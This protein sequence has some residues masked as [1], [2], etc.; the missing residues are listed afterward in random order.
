MEELL[1]DQ[2]CPRSANQK[3]R[4]PPQR[5]RQYPPDRKEKIFSDWLSTSEAS[6]A[7]TARLSKVAINVDVDLPHSLHATIRA[8]QQL[9]C[10]KAPESDAIPTEVYKHGGP[11]LMDHPTALFLEMWPH[12]EVPQD[13]KDASIHLEQGLL[14]ESQFGLRSHH[15]TKGVIFAAREIQEKFQQMRTHLHYIFVDLMKS[16]NMVDRERL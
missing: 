3:H 10:G 6:D 1:R 7:A 11:Q 14:L 13:F 5:R 8:V 9:S 2:S 12:A 15:G 4:S 16:F